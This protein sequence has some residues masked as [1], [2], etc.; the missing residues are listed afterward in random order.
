MNTK[1]LTVSRLRFV[2]KATTIR[3]PDD[4]VPGDT[5]LSATYCRWNECDEVIGD[6]DRECIQLIP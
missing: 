5:T 4:I 1:G 3:L 2:S 6:V